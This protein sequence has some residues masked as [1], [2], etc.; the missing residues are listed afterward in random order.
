MESYHQ[1]LGNV[2]R[3]KSLTATDLTTNAY[4]NNFISLNAVEPSLG[5][6]SSISN[7]NPLS[8]Y[9]FPVL[10]TETSYLS[11]RRITGKD[12][13]YVKGS[14]LYIPGSA[15]INNLSAN[16]A[17]IN[18]L[19]A[20]DVFIKNLTANTAFINELTAN[21][22]LI[23]N[24]IVDVSFTDSL[25]AKNGLIV[26][27]TSTN[28]FT[29]YLTASNEL[30]NNLTATNVFTNTLT[31][32]NAFTKLLTANKAL[33]TSLT[34]YEIYGFK[35]TD[36]GTGNPIPPFIPSSHDIV[37][38][39]SQGLIKINGGNPSLAAFIAPGSYSG[40]VASTGG[41][42][43]C[44]IAIGGTADTGSFNSSG[45]ALPA[46]GGD[47]GIINVSGASGSG[48]RSGG[49]GG[50]LLMVGSIS[51][52][53]NSGYNGGSINTS[54]TV[55]GSGGNITT[56]SGGGSINTTGSGYIQFGYDTQRTTLSGTATA[57]RNVNLPNASGTL[58][59]KTVSAIGNGVDKV[60]NFVHNLNSRDI[61]TQVYD[62]TN[63]EVVYASIANINTTTI[64]LS[65][66][67]VPPVN[68]YKVVVIG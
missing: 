54:A 64:S 39:G 48:T 55:Y 28:V 10:G 11:S 18:R 59:V 9:Y 53:T 33:I 4:V 36:T 31:T 2:V 43:G 47:A 21:T 38:G 15:I 29:N 7:A 50:S 13:L 65:F 61:I 27:L 51:N 40:W 60:I 22:A 8:A 37:P 30:V 12:T 63:Y 3:L 23:K 35:G 41:S 58:T 5:R 26:N 68:G 34:S 66:N 49:N 1:T 57:N 24:L 16:T 44:F 42:G 62:N 56:S 32:S 14:A 20:N 19:S 67:V 17:F 52:S 25:T 6:P 45:I 46:S